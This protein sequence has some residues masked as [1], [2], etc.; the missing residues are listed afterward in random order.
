MKKL[1]LLSAI[2][3]SINAYSSASSDNSI[4]KGVT[5]V[6]LQNGTTVLINEN[7]SQPLVSVQVWVKVGS[8]NEN[9]KT[10]GLSHFI[11]H[12]IFKGSKNYPGDLITRNTETNGGVINAATSKEFTHF[13]IDIQK[14]QFSNAVKM[15]A[16]AMSDALFPEA[17]IEFERPV[18][19]E[20]IIRSNDNPNSVI[21]D[22]FCSSIFLKTP[23]RKNVIGSADIIRSVSRQDIVNYYKSHYVPENMIVSVAGDFDEKE[24]L[25]L[26][27]DTFGKQPKEFAP[28]QPM[29]IEPE[30]KGN[31]LAKTKDLEQT[32]WFGG[33]IGPDIMSNDQFSADVTAT[34][35]GGG[36]SSRLNKTLREEKRLVYG[37]NASFWSQ[38]G[39]GIFVFSAVFEPKNS[40]EVVDVITSEINTLQAK[41]PTDEELARA[42]IIIKTQWYQGLETIHDRA[43]SM[44]YWYL[45][46]RPELADTYINNIE[47]V[48]KKD[49]TDF[50]DKYYKPYG[51][52]QA[53]LVPK[54]I[55]AK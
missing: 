54:Q 41:G 26:I 15:L 25:E 17:D 18:V 48:T 21:Y 13:H 1:L 38:K 11:E 10:S 36:R 37:V 4:F 9:E 44:G 2:M 47:K 8:N 45:L 28:A 7:H 32:Y 31:L 46:G 3:L 12:L 16:D 29:I 14:E 40:K 52:N 23:Y 34:I 27:K 19:V 42:K 20:E 33:F 55:N 53:E 35:L 49:V 51:L 6:R 5:K 24:A 39:S 43:S 30:H 50:L 22:L